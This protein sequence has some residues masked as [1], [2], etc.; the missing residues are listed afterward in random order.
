MKFKIK[1]SAMLALSEH[2]RR[3]DLKIDKSSLF[4]KLVP[5]M[6][7]IIT[8]CSFSLVHMRVGSMWWLAMGVR[9]VGLRM[10]HFL[11]L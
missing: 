10:P 9:T 1:Y 2:L 6:S 11:P 5:A 8:K 7:S 3:T 4:W